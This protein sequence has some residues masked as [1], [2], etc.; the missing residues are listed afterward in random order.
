MKIFFVLFVW[1]IQCYQAL[2]SNFDNIVR[3]IGNINSTSICEAFRICDAKTG[4]NEPEGLL[5]T[6]FQ[7]TTPLSG[8]CQLCLVGM[9]KIFERGVDR[10]SSA[11]IH[12]SLY[13]VKYAL[14]LKMEAFVY[15]LMVLPQLMFTAFE[16]VK[17]IS[18]SASIDPSSPSVWTGC[19]FQ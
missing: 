5:G 8:T 19:T 7:E 3:E 1:K 6:I 12:A 14:P 9:K 4:L 15:Y 17:Q 18:I 2:R 16:N 10:T 13:E 11:N